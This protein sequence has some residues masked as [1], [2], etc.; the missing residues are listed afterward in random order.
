VI[1]TRQV[2]AGEYLDDLPD[3]IVLWSDKTRLEKVWSE[4]LGEI[5]VP[6]PERRSGAH[7][8]TGFLM[9]SGPHVARGQ[10]TNE[11]RLVDL[12]PTILALLQLTPV[13]E[14]DGQALGSLL[15]D[16]TS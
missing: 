2:H 15:C 7:R 5:H 4:R 12:A 13:A 6:S 8:N 11:A 1:R 9:A 16:A 10:M 14:F 3:L